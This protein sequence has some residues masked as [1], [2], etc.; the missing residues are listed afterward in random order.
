MLLRFPNPSVLTSFLG[1]KMA[2]PF[3]LQNGHMTNGT[4]TD[5]PPVNGTINGS[6]GVDVNVKTLP[7][8]LLDLASGSVSAVSPPSG[9]SDAKSFDPLTPDVV[10]QSSSVPSE[11][12]TSSGGA[13]IDLDPLESLQEASTASLTPASPPADGAA[14]LDGFEDS[15]QKDSITLFGNTG[16]TL[17]ELGVLGAPPPTDTADPTSTN[18]DS[19]KPQPETSKPEVP[20]QQNGTDATATPPSPASPSKKNRESKLPKMTPPAS[21]KK[22]LSDPAPAPA[23]EATSGSA[24]DNKLFEKVPLPKEVKLPEPSGGARPKT[25]PPKQPASPKTPRGAAIKA[26][27]QKAAEEERPQSAPVSKIP[28]PKKE[29]TPLSTPKKQGEGLFPDFTF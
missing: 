5:S 18:G 12:T 9:A 14:S 16:N 19:G 7:A 15:V 20:S 27:A 10:S 24:D 6:N 4:G 13:L 11:P 22:K 25:A 23:P 8:E 1:T 26:H 29:R 21:P 3:D 2:D 28:S 17:E